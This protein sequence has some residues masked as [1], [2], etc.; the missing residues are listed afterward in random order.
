MAFVKCVC[1]CSCVDC[2]ILFSYIYFVASAR[3]A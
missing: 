1:V 2:D 3:L